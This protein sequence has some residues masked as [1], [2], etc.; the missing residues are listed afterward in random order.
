MKRCL[1][2][3]PLLVLSSVG[4]APAGIFFKK[5]PR[6]KPEE[7]V[8]QLILTVRT[9]G[10]EGKRADAAEELRRYDPLAFPQ[11]V[12]VLIEVLQRDKRSSVRAEAAQSLGRIRPISQEAGRA[13]E[14][15]IEMDPS[16]RVRLQA[17]SQLIQYHWAGYRRS[18]DE[19]PG[20]QTDEPPLAPEIAPPAGGNRPASMPRGP[21]PPPIRTRPQPAPGSSVP[22]PRLR[23]VPPMPPQEGEGP[24]LGPPPGG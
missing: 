22:L 16:L 4:P 10:D 9:D 11:I 5:R 24:R 6:V 8:P 13:L 18:K 14:R 19:P 17:R 1:L 23:P 15:A 20:P 7:R 2:L 21:F 3:V 12:P